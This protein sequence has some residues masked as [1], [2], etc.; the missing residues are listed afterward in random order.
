MMWYMFHSNDPA[1][2]GK[3]LSLHVM[4]INMYDSEKLRW[5]V[6]F[7][8]R[9][10]YS[11]RFTVRYSKT[12]QVPIRRRSQFWDVASMRTPSYSRTYILL[13]MQGSI[14]ASNP[15]AGLFPQ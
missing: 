7:S 14:L 3:P 11:Y 2:L 5:Y 10:R 15:S 1:T 13:A 8:T 4:A 12:S 9:R 6:L